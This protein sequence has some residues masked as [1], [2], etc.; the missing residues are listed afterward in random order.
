M[1]QGLDR[2]ARKKNLR[3]AFRARTDCR[4]LHIAVV[5]DV[6]TTA[7]TARAVAQALKAAGAEKI[8]IWCAA[9]TRL[10]K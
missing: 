7:S 10:E 1:Q 9:R 5:D 3:G 6:V 2:D 4:G 8:E